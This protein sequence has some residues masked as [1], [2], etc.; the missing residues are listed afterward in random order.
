MGSKAFESLPRS[1]RPESESL[2]DRLKHFCSS[3]NEVR[4]HCVACCE[5]R[6]LTPKGSTAAGDGDGRGE[7]ERSQGLDHTR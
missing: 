5:V 1:Y 7:R 3:I 4:A 2:R 6:M